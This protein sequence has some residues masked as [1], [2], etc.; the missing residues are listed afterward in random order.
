ML[1]SWNY[2]GEEGH[3]SLEIKEAFSYVYCPL[4]LFLCETKSLVV[5]VASMLESVGY[6]I[7]AGM[8][9]KGKSGGLAF[10][11]KKELSLTHSVEYVSNHCIH[12]K[13][14]INNVVCYVSCV[15]GYPEVHN[16]HQL[17]E[18][19]EQIGGHLSQPWVIIGDF[20]QF[21]FPSEKLSGSSKIASIETSLNFIQRLQVYPLLQKGCEYTW[22]NNRKGIY[23]V[24]EK[25]DKALVNA[26]WLDNFPFF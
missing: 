26:Q 21:F 11:V 2:R 10:A 5:D 8:D 7:L 20:N 18:Q 23:R 14:I 19:L 25:L 13:T 24:W 1:M 22:S 17:W 9:S 15:Y 3:G 6:I 16:R 12:I 4:M